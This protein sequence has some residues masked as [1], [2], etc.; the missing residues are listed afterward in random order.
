MTPSALHLGFSVVDFSWED[1]ADCFFFVAMSSARRSFVVGLIQRI[2]RLCA[3]GFDSAIRVGVTPTNVEVVGNVA[4]WLV[5][6]G[7]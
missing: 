2:V 6:T 5:P 4:N 1:V 3:F 7:V